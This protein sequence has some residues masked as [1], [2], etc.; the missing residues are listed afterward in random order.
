M[1]KLRSFLTWALDRAEWSAS[2]PD[3]FSLGKQTNKPCS[4]LD[5]GQ[6]KNLT[7]REVTHGTVGYP[8]GTLV[9][10]ANHE[11]NQ[12]AYIGHILDIY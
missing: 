11:L 6:E 9:T 5:A 1:G 3:C 2:C 12:S 4:L 8:A 10:V 7:C